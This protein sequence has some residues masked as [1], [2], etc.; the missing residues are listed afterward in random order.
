MQWVCADCHNIVRNKYDRAEEVTSFR[1][2]VDKQKFAEVTVRRLCVPCAR[3]AAL[4]L[5]GKTPDI[6]QVEMFS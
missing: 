1:K 6:E 3:E 2:S 4:Q 5:R